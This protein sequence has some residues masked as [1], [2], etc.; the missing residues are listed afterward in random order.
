ML[1]STAQALFAA[2][3][4]YAWQPHFL[5]LL[6]RE[7][8]WVAGVIAA[9]VALAT[10]AGNSV[11]EWL[12]RYCGKRTTLL[13][14]AAGVQTVAAVG[15]G[16]TSSFAVAVGLYLVVMATTGVWEPVRQAYLHQIIPSAQRATVVSFASLVSSAG[17]M[18]GQF[19]LGRL[20]Q[21]QSIAA[22]YV[23]GGLATVLA[24]PAVWALRRRRDFADVIVG[25]AG[26]RGICAAQG[27][28]AVSAVETSAA[29]AAPGG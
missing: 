24:L 6:G 26:T 5:A 27:L 29:V 3:G 11:V 20:A 19:G 18:A 2:W 14:W 16:L 25:R 17:S 13:L 8:P 7:L 22:G 28:P 4:F 10:M 21:T 9:L 23:V 15:V 1:A 12:T